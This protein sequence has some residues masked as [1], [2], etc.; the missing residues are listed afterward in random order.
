[1]LD[2]S[3]VTVVQDL[4]SHAIA[5]EASD[6]HFEPYQN[7]YRVRLRLDGILYPAPLP[8]PI[9]NQVSAQI[10]ARLKVMAKLDTTERRLPQDGRFSFTHATD[11]R[12]CRISTC[13]TLFGEKIVIRMLNPHKAALNIHQLGMEPLQKQYFLKHLQKP[14]GLL[15]ITGPTGS[16]KTVSLY[17][18]LSAINHPS[19]NISTVEEPVEIHLDGINQI[20]IQTKTGLDYATALRAL[21]RQ[22]PD[23]LVI[24]E[25]RDPQT[26]HIAIQAAQT[27]HL[28]LA[29]LHTNSA[30]EALNRL[31]NLGVSHFNIATSVTL[32]I[33]QRLAR[34]LCPNCK[35]SGSLSLPTGCEQ[36]MQGYQGRI[37]IFETLPLSP[38]L[39]HHI[40]TNK[41]S[42]DIKNQASQEGFQNLHQS[43]LNK[44]QQGLTSLAEIERV[45]GL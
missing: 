5:Q 36:C 37:G 26:A 30:L 25:I 27:G 38:S 4:L 45:I 10:G 7:G 1:M 35:K 31:S 34:K 28:V 41:P 33:A 23:I 29:T 16:G 43:A 39:C 3:V 32:I 13:P 2:A 40:Y 9:T 18:A 6:I 24:G 20:D 19:K 12:D 22:D 8:V 14:Q 42:Q 44:V 21:L 11:Q 17:A 15:L